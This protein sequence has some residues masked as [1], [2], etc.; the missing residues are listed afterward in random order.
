M[1]HTGL[2]GS[3]VR[4]CALRR[5]AVADWGPR[6]APK[7]RPRPPSTR[8]FDAPFHQVESKEAEKRR[9]EK[10]KSLKRL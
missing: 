6:A 4:P 5:P 1:A 9:Q 7:P 2:R 10:K 3:V 8:R